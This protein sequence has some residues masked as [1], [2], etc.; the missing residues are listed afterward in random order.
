MKCNFFNLVAATPDAM[1]GS[2]CPTASLQAS[3]V[4][5][6]ETAP[7][8]ALG[9]VKMPTL[10]APNI[11]EFRSLVLVLSH[12]Q[13]RVMVTVM[14]LQLTIFGSTW[15]VGSAKIRAQIMFG[16]SSTNSKRHMFTT[17]ISIWSFLCILTNAWA[18]AQESWNFQTIGRPSLHQ[19]WLFQ[20]KL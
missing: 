3:E 15:L 11:A 7:S 17:K 20:Q 6:A 8:P 13:V 2:H 10:M 14:V 16:C 19:K 1:T 5:F 4:W 9:P 12:N 18:C